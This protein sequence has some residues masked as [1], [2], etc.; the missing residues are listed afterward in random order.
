MIPCSQENLSILSDRCRDPA[1]SVKKKA[2]QCL[3]DLLL[4]L[5]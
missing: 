5:P 2:L 4:A 3:M 1:V